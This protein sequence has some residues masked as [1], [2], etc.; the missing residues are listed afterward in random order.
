MTAR[1]PRERR[2]RRLATNGLPWRRDS[3]SGIVLASLS[4]VIL[5][6]GCQPSPGPGSE[7]AAEA[8]AVDGATP[9]RILIHPIQ[10]TGDPAVPGAVQQK[11]WGLLED[12]S[13]G[14]FSLGRLDGDHRPIEPRGRQGASQLENLGVD[15]VVTGRVQAPPD[16]FIILELLHPPQRQPVWFL[17]LPLDDAREVEDVA[18]DGVA[19][20]ERALATRLDGRP[21]MLLIGE[22]PPDGA[23]HQTLEPRSGGLDPG[24]TGEGGE[25]SLKRDM[26]LSAMM[27]GSALV[28]G[29]AEESDASEPERRTRS[30]SD[31][32]ARPEL[33]DL[34]SE[35]G[36]PS[37]STVAVPPVERVGERRYRY[38][39]QVGMALTDAAVKG[40]VAKLRQRGF[41]PLVQRPSAAKGQR[42]RNFVWLG[43]YPDAA[44]ARKG[45]QALKRSGRGLTGKV[46]PI[47][48]DSLPVAAF[49]GGSVATPYVVQVGAYRSRI[50]AGKKMADLRRLGFKPWLHESGQGRDQ[51]HLIWIGRFQVMNDARR[52]RDDFRRQGGGSAVVRKVQ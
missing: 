27:A 7:S 50:E 44:A 4:L 48:T 3:L 10:T 22:E 24:R 18:R 20:L 8:G 13:R 19:Q 34:E 40:L 11:I 29:P 17:D 41:H 30:V 38:A 45:L 42:Q 21:A 5:L 28:L 37:R 14:R 47:P 31:G 39:V 23:G 9:L 2:G 16:G 12:R 6:I 52:L 32:R 51:W 26:S 25:V 49:R 35:P 1:Q 15:Y 36:P 33:A 46:I 43:R